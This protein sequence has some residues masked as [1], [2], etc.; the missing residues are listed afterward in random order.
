MTPF[1]FTYNPFVFL[2]LI[3]IV[4]YSFLLIHIYKLKST[5]KANQWFYAYLIFS[6]C[7]GI[8]CILAAISAN[9]YDA[10]IWQSLFFAIIALSFPLQL[11]FMLYHTNHTKLISKLWFRIILFIPG[12]TI[13][14]LSIFTGAIY[15]HDP[16]KV[17][18][19]NNIWN[20]PA[21]PL[22]EPLYISHI[23]AV[24]WISMYFFGKR[25]LTVEDE[26]LK[27]Q[28]K[29][30]FFAYFI[31][32][33]VDTLLILILPKIFDRP[34]IPDSLVLTS[35]MG[36]MI[37]WG[38][39]KYDLFTINPATAVTNIISTMNE[40]L[41][42]V[43]PQG[44]IEFVNRAAE[45]VLGYKEHELVG[46]HVKT[47]LSEDY[48]GHFYKGLLEPAIKDKS[49]NAMEGSIKTKEGKLYPVNF[50]VSAVKDNN[51][52]VA[53][54]VCVATDISHLRELYNVTSQR[55]KLNAI[56]DSMSDGII[57]LD[58]KGRIVQ[59]NRFIC[60]LVGIEE[61]NTLGKKIGE[62]LVLVDGEK[63][64]TTEQILGM[65]VSKPDEQKAGKDMK[66]KVNDAES[67]F[68]RLVVTPLSSENEVMEA[69]VIIQ[70]LT[71]E[72]ALDE[73][74]VDFVSMAAHEL[75][76]PLTAVR[77]YVSL[78]KDEYKDSLNEDQT[79]LIDRA[80]E[81]SKK[82]GELVEG[83]LSVIRMDRVGMSLN[84]KAV[85]WG[86][87]MNRTIND[88]ESKASERSIRL[89]RAVTN[90]E[91]E[92]IVLDEV[93]VSEVISNLINNA[94][95][96]SP[97]GAEVKIWSEVKNQDLITYVEDKGP[98]I[99][100]ASIPHLFSKFFRVPGKLEQTNR[101]TGLGLYISKKI[102]EMHNGKI[103]VDSQEGRGTTFAFSLPLINVESP[104]TT[105]TSGVSV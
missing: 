19:E 58:K 72:H 67:K 60:H 34:M 63:N 59:M 33:A 66:L 13:S 20:I 104:K 39:L 76:T 68:V 79:V 93:R 30:F 28:S 32:L 94:I 96:Y 51:G 18:F 85:K 44:N 21:G 40:V 11:G 6:I 49:H 3:A 89:I 91:P 77:G 74:K 80:E 78:F 12:I 90:T 42:V 75:R 10:I 56:M 45:K 101:G 23:M 50:S 73:M 105:E 26:R 88:L 16:S 99:P 46:L 27:K 37:A 55:N 24:F 71:E 41:I 86:E 87:F 62:V 64:V 98:G 81:A 31:Q 54:I 92:T 29:L 95:K 14:I 57:A 69:I 9:V 17:T 7:S 8:P 47:I 61:K 35:I 15:S 83:L 65:L 38:I 97:N 70:D 52:K 43:N 2:P 1:S 103:W 53:G 22:F 84:M 48:W 25:A 5:S 82:L 4:I 100:K 102:V 36:A